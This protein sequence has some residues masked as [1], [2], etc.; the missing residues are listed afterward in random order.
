MRSLLQAILPLAMVCFLARTAKPW[1]Q[2]AN[3]SPFCCRISW[4]SQWPM[5][6][7]PSCLLS[8][9]IVLVLLMTLLFDSWAEAIDLSVLRRH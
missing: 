1:C 7:W 3:L 8:L 2:V 9:I 4:H 6:R 5:C